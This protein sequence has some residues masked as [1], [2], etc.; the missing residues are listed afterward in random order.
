[1]ALQCIALLDKMSS[2]LQIKNIACQDKIVIDSIKNRD[3]ESFE[4]FYDQYSP[5]LYGWILSKMNDSKLSEEILLNSFLRI[6]EKIHL[7]DSSKCKFFIW[8]L[9]ITSIEI[10]LAWSTH[11]VTD[12]DTLTRR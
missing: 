2:S 4:I 3:V 6:W 12:K 10:K 5:A 11:A 1:M 9:Q 8:M 7:Y